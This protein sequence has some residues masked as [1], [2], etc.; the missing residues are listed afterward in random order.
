MVT[1]GWADRSR[2]WLPALGAAAGFITWLY[3]YDFLLNPGGPE[4]PISEAILRV[5][6]LHDA[7]VFVVSG[8]PLAVLMAAGA[9]LGLALRALLALAWR[10]I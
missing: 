3:D 4:A 5:T 9:A 7:S 6:K 1:R 2:R 8:W 10:R